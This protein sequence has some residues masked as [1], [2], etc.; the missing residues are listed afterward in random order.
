MPTRRSLIM[1]AAAAAAIPIVARRFIDSAIAQEQAGAETYEY[2]EKQLFDRPFA[3]IPNSGM[4]LRGLLQR[5]S[6]PDPAVDIEKY[7]NSRQGEHLIKHSRMMILYREGMDQSVLN[8]WKGYGKGLVKQI[9]DTDTPHPWASYVPV[10]AFR[11]ENRHRTYPLVFQSHQKVDLMG[12]SYGHAFVCAE[13]EVILV[14][15][16]SVVPAAQQPDHPYPNSPAMVLFPPDGSTPNLDFLWTILQKAVGTLPVDHSRIYATGFSMPGE[17]IVELTL[18]HP[19]TFAGMII[20]PNM[21]PYRWNLPSREKIARMAEIKMPIINIAGK[22]DYGR[23][24]PVYSAMNED[25]PNGHD[26]DR[27]SEEALKRP[28]IWLAVNDC[29]A[30]TMEQALATKGLPHDNAQYHVGMPL[31]NP[32]TVA[33]DDTR[34]FIG[35]TASRDKVV[36]MRYVVM[37]NVPHWPAGSFARIGW[38]FIKHFSRNTSTLESVWDGKDT[39]ITG[40]LT[41]MS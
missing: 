7:I 12:E 6:A 32:K 2:P 34:H 19:A 8:F 10:S 26:H 25:T 21:W 22:S 24:F 30:V 11:P 17:M 38:D 16:F 15:P 39:P 41:M 3:S 9:H 14:A 37:E 28:N 13:D 27:T 4:T 36:R 40:S 35:D 18:E 33:I 5:M 1:G 23:P 29:P 20:S 31:T